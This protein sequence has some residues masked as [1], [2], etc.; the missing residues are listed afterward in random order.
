MFDLEEF[1]MFLGP[2]ANDYT[3]PQL[4][5]LRAELRIMAELL[6]DIYLYRMNSGRAPGDLRSDLTAPAI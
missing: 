2:V 6:L 1:K 5:K 4:V 3:D